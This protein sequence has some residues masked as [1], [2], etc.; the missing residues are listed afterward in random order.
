MTVAIVTDSGSDLSPTQLREGRIRQV[1]L[2]VAFGDRS[3]LCPDELAPED[4]WLALRAPDSPFPRTAAP[5][6]GQFKQAFEEALAGG[7]DA[8]VCICLG[9][10]I[11]ATLRS[12]QI[13]RAML[14]DKSIEVVDSQSASM[15]IGAMAI[16]AAKLAAEGLSA[17]GI[18]ERLGRLRETTTLFVAL[19]T[20]E[21]LR[22]G[23]RISHARAAIG[24]L[25][26]VKPIITIDD[27]LVVATDQPR[28]RAKARERLIELMSARPLEELHL[29]YSPPADEKAFREELLARLPG[30]APRLVTTQI[31]GPVIGAHV[32][33]GACGGVLVLAE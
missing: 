24:G 5:S 1:P 7:A 27:G 31:I 12:A 23:G 4:F 15:A 33:P 11:S 32:G 22:K 14:P 6:A 20:L 13:A 18:V 8:V 26:S 3:Y 25:L 28:T 16:R 21:Y 19:E 29:L 9:D 2:S 10:K 30:P 17:A